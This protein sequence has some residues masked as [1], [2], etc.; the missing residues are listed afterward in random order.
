MKLIRAA[1]IAGIISFAWCSFSWKVLPFHSQSHKTF[2][3]EALVKAAV[4]S[5]A[6]AS[7]V[8]TIEPSKTTLEGKGLDSA[9]M[10][11]KRNNETPFW[12]IFIRDLAR[13]VGIA[14]LLGIAIL[15]MRRLPTN[16][17]WLALLVG[18]IAGALFVLLAYFNWWGLSAL[19][20]IL[21]ILDLFIAWSL[22]GPI[23]IRMLK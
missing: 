16:E 6:K 7:G 19:N 23:L 3:N 12:V 5:D 15:L 1:I 10:V 11:L 20:V 13:Q 22:A 18:M 17:I 21:E 4:F 8:Y 2:R 14:F 9:F